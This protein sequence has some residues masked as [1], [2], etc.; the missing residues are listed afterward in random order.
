MKVFI[1][2]KAEK[3]LDRIPDLFARNVSQGILSLSENPFPPASKKLHG[4]ENWRL[5]IGD[6]RI[7]YT[8]DKKKNE[9]TVL[10]IADR[11]TVYR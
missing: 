10:R 11:K 7:I 5:R 6:F 1:T 4:Q 3:E 8:I 2:K 9:L